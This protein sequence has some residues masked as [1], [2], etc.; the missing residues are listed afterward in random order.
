MALFT[1]VAYATIVRCLRYRRKA[2]IEAHF[3]DGKRSLSDMTTKEAHEIIAQL[4]LLEFPYAFG[5]ARKI[6]LLK[7][8]THAQLKIHNSETNY[9]AGGWYSDHVQAVCCHWAKH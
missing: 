6:A 7:V 3:A 4:Q 2:A 9:Q 5:K 1:L 8:T